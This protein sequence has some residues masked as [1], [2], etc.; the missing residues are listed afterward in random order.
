VLACERV[1][2]DAGEHPSHAG[3]G[4]NW[5]E[6][7]EGSPEPVRELSDPE[8][9]AELTVAAYAPGRARFERFQRLLAERQRRL[10]TI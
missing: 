2:A 5:H 10:I 4:V 6:Q 3:D 8:L 9:E 7:F 1:R